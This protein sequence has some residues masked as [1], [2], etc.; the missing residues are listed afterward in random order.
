MPESELKFKLFEVYTSKIEQ[1]V[2]IISLFA[3]DDKEFEQIT[4]PRELT[5]SLKTKIRTNDNFEGML[6]CDMDIE[7]ENENKTISIHCI[8]T[9]V[10][11]VKDV[12]LIMS[13]EDQKFSLTKATSAIVYPYL[14]ELITDITRR[15]PLNKSIKLPPH[16]ELPKPKGNKAAKESDPNTT[17]KDSE[18]E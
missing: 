8:V 6:L 17:P 12:K 18:A 2:D 9:G 5:L 16:Y 14:R 3:K 7:G 10:F 11:I 4:K 15:L 1:R 13:N